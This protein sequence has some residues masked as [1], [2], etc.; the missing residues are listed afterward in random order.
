MRTIFGILDV[1][2]N[3]GVLQL[4][5]DL[6]EP[7]LKIITNPSYLNHAM[8]LM[9]YEVVAKFLQSMRIFGS[10]KAT[11]LANMIF[12]TERFLL[13]KQQSDGSWLKAGGTFADQYKSTAVCAKYVERVTSSAK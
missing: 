4:N 2:S 6:F 1:V 12:V 3:F 9:E 5:P 13:I 10:S 8:Y 11:E 7:E